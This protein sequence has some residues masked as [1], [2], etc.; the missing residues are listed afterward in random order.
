MVSAT[1]EFDFLT[2][3]NKGRVQDTLVELYNY[4][5]GKLEKKKW[6]NKKIVIR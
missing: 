5:K 3:S 6:F 1:S 2:N 4:F